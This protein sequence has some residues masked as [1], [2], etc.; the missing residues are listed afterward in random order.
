MSDCSSIE[1][2]KIVPRVD[3]PKRKC[4]LIAPLTKCKAIRDCSVVIEVAID[5]CSVEESTALLAVF[6]RKLNTD[7]FSVL[8]VHFMDC[9]AFFDPFSS[10]NKCLARNT[11]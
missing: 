2:G 4:C 11:R 10:G 6:V 7:I 3:D 1:R 5:D 8:L 9:L